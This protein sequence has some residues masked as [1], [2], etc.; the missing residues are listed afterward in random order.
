[1]TRKEIDTLK[2]PMPPRLDPLHWVA[3]GALTAAQRLE[4]WARFVDRHTIET[5]SARR[6]QEGAALTFETDFDWLVSSLFVVGD[7]GHLDPEFPC[8]TTGQ[9]FP[10]NPE[11]WGPEQQ[12]RAA[13]ARRAQAPAPRKRVTGAPR[14]PQH[15]LKNLH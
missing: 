9:T 11:L 1:M 10:R 4:A 2:E 3:G 5:P 7:D 8:V 13:A 12:A 15:R 14:P 6:R